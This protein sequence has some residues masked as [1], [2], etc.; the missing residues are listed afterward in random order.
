M[1][2]AVKK[3]TK[4]VN[5]YDVCEESVPYFYNGK[6]VNYRDYLSIIEICKGKYEYINGKV[7]FLPARKKDKLYEQTNSI[8]SSKF[9]TWF[10]NRAEQPLTEEFKLILKTNDVNNNVVYPDI[11]VVPEPNDVKNKNV[12]RGIPS[13]IV[14]IATKYTAKKNYI[15]KLDLYLNA[16]VFEYWIV[17][18]SKKRFLKV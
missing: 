17:N 5:D 10:I 1:I 7:Y 18:F 8:L 12:Y 13:L 11:M 3:Y 16:G 9:I 15:D 6:E 2:S 14:E 4:M